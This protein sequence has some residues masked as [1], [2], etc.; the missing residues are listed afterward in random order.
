M[1][2]G[3]EIFGNKARKDKAVKNGDIL[4]YVCFVDAVLTGVL[5]RL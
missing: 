1:E 3:Q 5:H 4:V 2:S